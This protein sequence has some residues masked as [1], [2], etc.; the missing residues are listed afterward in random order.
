MTTERLTG[1]ALTRSERIIVIALSYI[2]GAP[3]LY[4]N[5]KK[6]FAFVKHTTEETR[7]QLDD[8][9]RIRDRGEHAEA[10]LRDLEELRDGLQDRD[11]AQA[12]G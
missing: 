1:L 4:K 12:E 10:L 3:V 6:L 5:I 8:Q 7:R 2:F 11:Q 9:D